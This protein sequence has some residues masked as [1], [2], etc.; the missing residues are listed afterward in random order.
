MNVLFNSRFAWL[1]LMLV[2]AALFIPFI[3]D[4]NLFDW[5]EVNF[6]ECAREMLVTGNYS[7]VQIAYKPFWEKPPLFIWM[8]A[9]SMKLF[10]I[11][12]FSARFPNALCGMLTLLTVFFIGKQLQSKKLGLLW[13]LMV[14]SAL[15]PHFYFKSGIIDPWFNLFILISLYLAFDLISHTATKKFGSAFLGGF[16]LGL[17][18]LTK[19]PVAILVSGLSIL[20]FL[21]WSSRFKKLWSWPMLVFMFSTLVVSASWFVVEW[22]TGN[23]AVVEEFIQYQIRLFNTEDSGHSGPFLYHALVLLI[24]CFPVSFLFLMAYRKSKLAGEKEVLF[25]KM[26]LAL[27]WVV[28]ILF[29]LVKTKIIHYSSLCY[30]PLT[31]IAALGLTKPLGEFNFKPVMRF[32]YLFIALLMGSAFVALGFIEQ[33]KHHLIAGNWIQDPFAKQCL[34]AEVHWSGF[35][36]L[37]GLVFLLGCLLIASGIKKASFSRVLAGS[38]VNV[39]FINLAILILVPKIE[40]YTQKASIDF[41]R[42]CSLHPNYIETRG[43]KS[44]AYLFYSNRKPGDY[45]NAE[46]LDY[47]EAQLDDMEKNGYQR[48]TS[49]ALANLLWL[50]NGKIDRP[51]F[52]VAKT[53]DDPVVEENK[54]LAKLYNK[55]GYSFYVRMPDGPAK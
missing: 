9:G 36:F 2:S 14:A 6:A 8:Q 1:W 10:G 3:G 16:T 23:K 31:Y 15:L 32:L 21:V 38:A 51:A 13:A 46:Q 47:V 48:L 44:Y 33:F 52:V 12:E 39:L 22:M 18:V 37:L 43:F 26:M 34:N 20:I 29:S 28:L 17:A 35:E 11:T 25:R 30:F 40:A 50:E 4:C 54:N 19:G 53:I 5:D 27:F 55:N 24:G 49:H 7:Q 45:D 41:Y 42:S